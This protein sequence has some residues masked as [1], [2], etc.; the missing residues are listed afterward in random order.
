MA[1]GEDCGAGVADG[2]PPGVEDDWALAT[3]A[4]SAHTV[5]SKAVRTHRREACFIEKN[6]FD[7]GNKKEGPEGPSLPCQKG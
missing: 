2:E 3:L 4:Y 6:R 1:E 5:I 7:I